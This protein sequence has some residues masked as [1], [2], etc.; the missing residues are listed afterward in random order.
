MPIKNN[1]PYDKISFFDKSFIDLWLQKIFRNIASIKYQFM[2][3]F[4]VLISYGMFVE[5]N[6]KGEPFISVT[7][8]LGFLG[9]AFI[10]LATSRI[11]ARTSLFAP[12]DGENGK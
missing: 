5:K 7:L 6:A 2:V 1:N 8:G 12:K 4:F 9:G 10:T 11:I 3:A